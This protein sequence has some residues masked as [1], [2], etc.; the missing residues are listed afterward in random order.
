MLALNEDGCISICH[1]IGDDRLLT[2]TPLDSEEPVAPATRHGST[3]GTDNNIVDDGDFSLSRYFITSYGACG[4]EDV[5][6][7]GT[8]AHVSKRM[9]EPRPTLG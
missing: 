3:G 7:G 5:G 2:P 6:G 9:T 8:N 1:P 4:G